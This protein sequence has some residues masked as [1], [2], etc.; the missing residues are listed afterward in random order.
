MKPAS[1]ITL[2]FFTFSILSQVFAHEITGAKVAVGNGFANTFVITNSKMQPTSLGIELTK[3]ALNGLPTIDQ[4]Y[5]LKLP[6]SIEVPP[7]NEIIV[8]WNAMGHEPPDIYGIPHFDFHFYTIIPEEREAIKCMGDDIPLC[9]KLPI[10][11]F[12]A[13]FYIPTP[14][15]VPM[16][17]WH[18]LDSRSPELNGQRFTSTFIYG[19]YNGE[20]IFLE[21][22]I[23]REFMLGG[24]TVNQKLS[25]PRIYPFEG[26]YPVKYTFNYNAVKK[27][28]R[29]T[30]AGLVLKEIK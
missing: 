26:Y 18:W 24:G 5:S 14:A 6:T 29:V 22:M 9:Q 16:M 1:L 7:Y 17:G 30:L 10:A 15:G 8:N 28:Y 25:I 21:P 20:M 11:D 27:V 19:Y 13:P 2:G 12:L 3:E 4:S 23:T